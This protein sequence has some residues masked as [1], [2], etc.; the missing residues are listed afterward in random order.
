M[1]VRRSVVRDVVFE[2]EKEASWPL[3]R[4]CGFGGF[5]VI[6]IGWEE[7]GLVFVSSFSCILIL[8]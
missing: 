6:L 4:R 5:L 7:E 8:V 2:M 3:E 1:E